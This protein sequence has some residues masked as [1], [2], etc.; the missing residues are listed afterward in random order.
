MD[1][2]AQRNGIRR[3]FILADHL[4]N[5]GRVGKMPG[6]HGVDQ[7]LRLQL[8]ESLSVLLVAAGAD[9]A[10]NRKIAGAAGL[11]VAPG[12]LGQQL[13]GCG[14]GTEAAHRHRHIFLHQSD[15]FLRGNKLCHG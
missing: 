14:I 2:N 15:C 4:R 8:A 13:I 3:D 6:D 10:G 7:A 5:F 11:L 9:A 1:H 12:Q